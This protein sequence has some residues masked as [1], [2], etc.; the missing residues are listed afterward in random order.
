MERSRRSRPL[1]TPPA[2]AP[3]STSLRFAKPAW[4]VSLPATSGSTWLQHLVVAA[5]DVGKPQN[6]RRLLRCRPGRGNHLLGHGLR[7]DLAE[8][9]QRTKDGGCAVGQA[10]PFQQAREDHAVIDPDGEIA[11]TDR[12]H[13]IVDHQGRFDVGGDRAGADGVEI[14]LHEL[15]IA[16]AL[17]VLAPPYRGDVV[18]L[19]RDAQFVEMFGGEAGQRHRQVEPQPH[20]A[21]AVV[22]KLVELLVGLF[23]PLAGQ[24]FQVLQGGRVDGAEAVGAINPP[25]R[26]DQ[27]FARNHRLRRI[28]AETLQRAGGDALGFGQLRG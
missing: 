11:E 2:A 5:G 4:P 3:S 16:A 12:S 24:D 13:Q 17:S 27:P 19:E 25:G 28:I 6:A 26:V 1:G 9:V 7:A 15:A 23:A 22:L 20:P 18:S 14:A 10:E 21:A 8:F